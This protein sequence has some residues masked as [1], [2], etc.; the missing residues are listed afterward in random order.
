MAGVFGSNGYEICNA[1]SYEDAVLMCGGHEFVDEAL[2]PVDEAL[3]KN[4]LGFQQLHNASDIRFAKTKL[5]ISK[6]NPIPAMTLFFT[7]D[8][9]KRLVTKLHVK[10]SSPESMAFGA[11]PWDD[12]EPPF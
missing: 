9:E 3:N 7:V 5:R 6:G 10:Y 1:D 8:E 2:S 11:N 12:G 4:P